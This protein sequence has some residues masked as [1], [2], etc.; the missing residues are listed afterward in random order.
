M[1]WTKLAYLSF[2]AAFMPKK[3]PGKGWLKADVGGRYRNVLKKEFIKAGVPWEYDPQTY[4]RSNSL[5]PFQYPPK[6]SKKLVNKAIRVAKIT[7][8]L[9][10]QD[11]LQLKY[12]QERA[13][14]KR[15]TGFDAVIQLAIINNLKRK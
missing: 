6:E 9:E 1:V 12:R 15:L 11:E 10:K 8:A 7:K 14:K 13:N 2:P 3:L 4:K 5:H